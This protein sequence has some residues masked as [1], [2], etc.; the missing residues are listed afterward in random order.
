MFSQ[1]VPFRLYL[2]NYTYV[3]EGNICCEVCGKCEPLDDRPASAQRFALVHAACY[4][5]HLDA[6]RKEVDFI[7]STLD[8]YERGDINE[9]QLSFLFEAKDIDPRTVNA[10]HNRRET[11]ATVR[12]VLQVAIIVV[13]LTII[14]I[15]ITAVRS[16]N[17][18]G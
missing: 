12:L 17:A 4:Q 11:E 13:I 5:K 1:H 3:S 2:D 16:A 14:C 6:H 9:A 18:A 8:R 10:V 7:N 15:I